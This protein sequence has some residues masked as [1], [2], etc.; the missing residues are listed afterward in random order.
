MAGQYQIHND[1]LHGSCVDSLLASVCTLKWHDV[2]WQTLRLKCVIQR[3]EDIKKLSMSIVCKHSSE[4]EKD[5]FLSC[6][7]SGT[8]KNSESPWGIKPQTFGIL[9]S[10]ALPLSH[11]DSAVSEVYYEVHMTHVLHTTRISNVNSIMFVDRNKR[12]GKFWAK[13]RN[14]EKWCFFILSWGWDKEKFWVLMKNQ[15]SHLWILHSDA[16]PLSYRDS[17]ESKV[18]YEVHGT[19][20]LHAARIS[21]VDS[22]MFVDRNKIEIF[23]QNCW[24][25]ILKINAD[26]IQVW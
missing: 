20:V 2:S 23:N 9:S 7:E 22:E 21:N 12:D 19:C 24:K 6:H 5:V 14:R 18:Y 13:L 3:F 8:R 16:L 4:L 10:D 15:T 26:S 11:R 25:D 1:F 17:T